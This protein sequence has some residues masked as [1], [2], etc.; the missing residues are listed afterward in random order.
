MNVKFG[1]EICESWHRLDFRGLLIE[2]HMSWEII[3]LL[4]MK[5][6]FRD[7]EESKE[8]NAIAM[9]P[10]DAIAYVSDREIDR[11]VFIMSCSD[12]YS[13]FVA[14]EN[15]RAKDRAMCFR[16]FR[17][18]VL[19][20]TMSIHL[21]KEVIARTYCLSPGPICRHEVAEAVNSIDSALLERRVI[22]T[23]LEIGVTEE[24]ADDQTGI[25]KPDL[26]LN[27]HP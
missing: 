2:I 22:E 5:P 4:D 27:F 13:C 9:C 10:S 12:R 25:P 6:T 11:P 20:N 8:H 7:C 15:D 23:R 17:N 16:I 19:V 24:I 1:G 14:T 3:V 26:I 21:I 18:N